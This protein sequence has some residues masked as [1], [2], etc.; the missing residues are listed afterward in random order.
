MVWNIWLPFGHIRHLDSHPQTSLPPAS[1]MES[2]NPPSLQSRA[3][4][5]PAVHQRSFLCEGQMEAMPESIGPSPVLCTDPQV[6]IKPNVPLNG[7]A[8]SLKPLNHI[9][10]HLQW[11]CATWNTCLG[12]VGI[13]GML[14]EWTRRNWSVFER[15]RCDLLREKKSLSVSPSELA[16]DQTDGLSA[17][18]PGWNHSNAAPGNGKPC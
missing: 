14:L 5:W 13:P 9:K 11:S 17:H 15:Q 3:D 6:A 10:P 12:K 2:F 4:C 16:V 1:W 18:I 8:I 7:G